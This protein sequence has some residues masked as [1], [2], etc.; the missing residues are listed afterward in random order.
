[1]RVVP[2]P[3]QLS[4]LSSQCHHRSVP[5]L[6]AMAQPLVE[7]F[8]AGAARAVAATMAHH[9]P[10]FATPE[11]VPPTASLVASEGPSALPLGL[12]LQ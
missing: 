7:T 9:L 11:G 6:L 3:Q 12:G 10:H 1:M 5:S 4:P 8:H 2:Q